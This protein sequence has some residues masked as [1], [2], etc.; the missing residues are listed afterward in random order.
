MSVF[1][2]ALACPVVSIGTGP[3][4]RIAFVS[5]FPGDTEIYVME[6][7]GS[8]PT[9]LTFSEEDDYSPTWSPDGSRI[10]FVSNRDR[11]PE[12][13]PEIYVMDTDGSNQ[14]R[15]TFN[16]ASS[17]AW[18]PDGSR[19]AFVSDRD[20]NSKIYVMDAD[21]SNVTRLTFHEGDDVDPAWSPDGSRIAFA[22]NRHGLDNGLDKQIY[23]MDT[24]GSNI[25]RLTFRQVEQ[26]KVEQGE[27]EEPA[28]SPD[29]SRIAFVSSETGNVDIYL[30]NPDGSNITRVTFNEAIDWFPTWSP[31]G[32]RIAFASDRDGPSGEIYVMDADGSNVT[33][34]T[35]SEKPAFAPAW[36][37]GR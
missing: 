2:S 11:R 26:G 37:P 22:S 18:S 5:G 20:G 17:P 33:R 31:D 23:V 10:A 14:T 25:I 34:L 15:L 4:E 8:S 32:S 1:V 24:D 27:K 21:G 3:P 35:F 9:R 6:A 16:E 12:Y 36:S 29:G 28:W 19:I 7:D 30:M 13:V